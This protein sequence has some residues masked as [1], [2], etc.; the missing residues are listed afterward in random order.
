MMEIAPSIVMPYPMTDI[1][2]HPEKYGLTI[3]DEQG[4]GSISDYLIMDSETMDRREIMGAYQEYLQS[5]VDEVKIMLNDGELSH[6]ALSPFEYEVMKYCTGKSTIKAITDI[7]YDR[8]GKPFGESH[9]ELM[10]R[11]IET[12][13]ILIKNTGFLLFRSRKG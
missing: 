3:Y 13:K 1:C 4:L 6:E 11:V 12:L 2:L 7:L 8:F 5:F 10:E 9:D